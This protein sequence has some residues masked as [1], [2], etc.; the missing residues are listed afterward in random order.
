MEA[1]RGGKCIAGREEGR[2]L[3]AEGPSGAKGKGRRV[4]AKDMNKAMVME[5]EE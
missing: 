3:Q 5:G 4:C 2:A 1:E